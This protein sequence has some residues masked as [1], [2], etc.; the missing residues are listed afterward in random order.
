MPL[1]IYPKNQATFHAF[2][3]GT[4]AF[5]KLLDDD[6]YDYYDDDDDKDDERCLNDERII[7]KLTITISSIIIILIGF[8]FSNGTQ[9]RNC[10][11]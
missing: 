5:H 7:S 8:S 9:T 11:H 6:D 10:M 3:L 4:V 1:K 2:N